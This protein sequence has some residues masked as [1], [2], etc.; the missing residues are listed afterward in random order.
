MGV[1]HPWGSVYRRD[2]ILPKPPTP[3]HPP[4]TSRSSLLITLRIGR[5]GRAGQGGF[6]GS[7]CRTGASPQGCGRYNPSL[8]WA[9]GSWILWILARTVRAWLPPALAY[10]PVSPAF[11]LSLCLTKNRVSPTTPGQSEGHSDQD[12]ALDVN[13]TSVNRIGRQVL[14]GTQSVKPLGREVEQRER[15][16][17][18]R[19]TRVF[20]HD[21]SV[22]FTSAHGKTEGRETSSLPWLLLP[23][24]G[25][26]PRSVETWLCRR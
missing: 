26:S 22:P 14:V 16:S 5:Q 13:T 21:P 8:G 3:T 20:A 6:G 11:A 23:A 12:S 17:R 10:G 24:L 2:S 1:G 25:R 9:P 7:M 19:N 4:R 15:F 18:A